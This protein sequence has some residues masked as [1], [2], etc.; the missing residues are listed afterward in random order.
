MVQRQSMSLSADPLGQRQ[1]CV[2]PRFPYIAHSRGWSA[3]DMERNVAY[4][5]HSEDLHEAAAALAQRAVDTARFL[6]THSAEE[7]MGGRHEP[8]VRAGRKAG[9]P[10]I[11]GRGQQQQLTE[12]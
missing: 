9:Q 10:M 12:G 7:A 1:L 11:P 6:I 2:F 5:Q 8:L 4:V 3:E